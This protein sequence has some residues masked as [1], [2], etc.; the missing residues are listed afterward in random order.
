MKPE[1]GSLN[2]PLLSNISPSPRAVRNTVPASAQPLLGNSLAVRAER[3]ST[4]IILLAAMLLM[5]TLIGVCFNLTQNVARNT[6]RAA[7]MVQA[8]AVADGALEL[9]YAQWRNIC[10]NATGFAPGTSTFANITLPTQAMF[11]SVTA[12]G[13]TFA[14]SGSATGGAV[15]SNYK[16][17]AVDQF[18]NPLGSGTNNPT[19]IPPNLNGQT[20]WQYLATASVT[21][22]GMRSDQ[23]VS[24]ARVLQLVNRSPWTYAIMYDGNME[25]NPGAPMTITG[26]V[27]SNSML[28]Y[29]LGAGFL[30]FNGSVQSSQITGTGNNYAFN[31]PGM[32]MAGAAPQSPLGINRPANGDYHP[33]IEPAVTG[34]A[35]DPFT[36]AT[37]D[38]NNPPQRFYN[39]ADLKIILNNSG[40]NAI[41]SVVVYTNGASTSGSYTDVQLS[42]TSAIYR[43]LTQGYT[44]GTTTI[45]PVLTASGQYSSTSGSTAFT[46]NREARTMWSTNFNVANLKKLMEAG[47]IV[48]GT[49]GTPGV[50]IPNIFNNGG[51]LVYIQDMNA[52]TTTTEP[53]I[54]VTSGTALPTGGITLVS[55]NPVYILKDYN[56]GTWQPS[57]II[58]DA[59]TILSNSWSDAASSSGTSSR[60][61]SSTTVKA[62]FMSGNV[63]TPTANLG[64]NSA[65]T[66]S[67]GVENFPRFLEY[68]GNAVTFTYSGSMVCFYN[69]K[70]ATGLWGTSNVYQPPTRAWSWDSRF[71]TTPPPGPFKSTR[72]SKG[73]LLVR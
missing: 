31:V 30:T 34:T 66:Y 21:V 2:A 4:L 9:L 68:W 18:L 44:S 23:T 59:I 51:I 57:E 22:P 28:L 69:S 71:A 47:I 20:I 54:R 61:A 6:E 36:P 53:A 11:P 72:Y 26:D 52:K 50:T 64:T 12:T 14:T 40:T 27:F 29:N 5:I 10:T 46:D 24:L 8:R 60:M 16:I 7:S 41:G 33:L 42:S 13:G 65:G 39:A 73:I 3:G 17:V 32:P 15:I 43:G 56:T 45:G 35:V 1:I 38:P 58:G 62:A 48:T 63:S 67:G 55:P 37:P 25:I 70:T 49:S 19:T